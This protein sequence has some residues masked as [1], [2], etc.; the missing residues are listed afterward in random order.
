MG[1][2]IIDGTLVYCAERGER[3]EVKRRGLW[4]LQR[5]ERGGGKSLVSSEN[6]LKPRVAS[7]EVTF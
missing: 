3:K 6:L 1:N 4:E 7:M 2:V 5:L